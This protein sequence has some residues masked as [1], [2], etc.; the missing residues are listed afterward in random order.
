M[1][2]PS[3]E[4]PL[5]PPSPANV[6][7]DFTRPTA[8]YRWHARLALLALLGFVGFYFFLC[9]WFVRAVYRNGVLLMHGG[10]HAL[11]ALILGGVAFVLAL[12]L[13]KAMFKVKRAEET[14]R[15]ELR[16][17]S[18]PELFRFLYRLADEAGAPRPHRVFVSVRVN[19][20]V[21][22]DLSLLNLLLPSKKNLEIGLGLVNV[23]NLSEFKAVLAHEFGHFAQRSMAVGRWVYIAQQITGHLVAGRDWLD[24]LLLHAPRI[25]IRIAVVAWTLRLLVWAMRAV[26]DTAFS[27]VVLVDRALRREMEFQ[28]DLV[29]VSLSGSDALIHALHRLGAADDALD[30]AGAVAGAEHSQGRL[31]PD[32]F[33]IQSLVLESM[34]RV[35]NDP[36]YAVPPSLPESGREQHRIFPEE[37]GSPPRMWST[38]PSNQDREA[39]AKRVYLEGALDERPAWL[40]FSDPEG[41][42]RAVTAEAL[43]RVETTQE[44]REAT[45]EEAE[46]AVARRFSQLALN[47]RYRG[48]YLGRSPVLAASRVSDLFE[49]AGAN[50][51]LAAELRTL[52][53]EALSQQVE[54]LRDLRRELGVLEALKDGFL[55]AP[56]GV[57]RHRGED[58]RKRDLPGAIST[59]RAERDAVAASVAAHDRRCRSLH[60]QA[61]QSLGHGWEKYLKKLTA[62]LHYSAHVEADIDDAYGHLMNVFSV[63]I[64]DGSVS[65]SERVRLA[66][67]GSE[68]YAALWQADGQRKQVKVPE[69][70]L[71]RLEIESWDGAL[72]SR[73]DLE[74]PTSE[75]IGQWMQVV[76]SWYRAYTQPFEALRSQTLEEL[77]H[78][79]ARIAEWFLEEKEPEDAP[80]PARV[81]KEYTLRPPG[82]ERPRQHRL[83]AWDRFVTADGVLP[84]LGR[85]AVAGSIVGCVAA[86]SAAGSDARV[87][88]INGLGCHVSADIGPTHVELE[89]G[90]HLSVSVPPGKLQVT[91][92]SGDVAIEDVEVEAAGL[93][94]DYVYNVAAALPLVEWT[95]AYGSADEQSPTYLGAVRWAESDAKYFFEEPPRSVKIKGKGTTRKIVSAPPIHEAST[96]LNRAG[97][98]EERNHIIDVRARYD[99]PGSASLLYWLAGVDRLEGQA[100]AIVRERLQRNPHEVESLRAQQDLASSDARRDEVCAEHEQLMKQFPD[101][102]DMQY[103]GLRCMPD[104]EEQDAAI[105]ATFTRFPTNPWLENGAAWVHLQQNEF[106]VAARIF[107]HLRSSAPAFKSQAAMA[108]G[109]LK[110]VAPGSDY[111]AA[112]LE[113]DSKELEMLAHL[114]SGLELDETE[115]GYQFLNQG[116]LPTAVKRAEAIPS[117]LP[118]VIRFAAVSHGATPEIVER[119]LALPVD[120][121]VDA[122]TVWPALALAALNNRELDPYIKV[123]KRTLP[124]HADLLLGLL[125]KSGEKL[126]KPSDLDPQ[127]NRLPPDARARAY[128]LASSYLGDSAPLEWRRFAMNWL[129][130]PERPYFEVQ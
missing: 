15:R 83:G 111:G 114:E 42:R 125:A 32:L 35:V 101:D 33:A 53:P 94:T 113:R 41:L 97:T 76:D 21:F 7:K 124:E 60:L 69:P 62:L 20:G 123:A 96:I 116:D 89:P 8:R 128:V 95:A 55:S 49:S 108:L 54:R 36:E 34:A 2:S 70:V 6:P 74:P 45:E 19:A 3:D 93:G 12:V 112:L 58:L 17:E 31:A 91:A 9:F 100:E 1:R 51:D 22:Y 39:N 130:A 78:T 71:K 122:S 92:R 29:S 121:G 88:V 28:A 73:F 106:D 14:D 61:A 109:R 67:A 117:M 66:F 82:S 65:S 5:Y 84:A 4:A 110:R 63:V 59:V 16:P 115:R 38:H 107:N 99:A 26:L 47:P 127:L 103:I 72:Q 81:P 102:G 79:E 86:F 43:K 18:E 85:L 48:V 120:Q 50:V 105:L 75:N 25:D 129:F 126:V 119:A 13:V 44:M 104:G 57:I 64:A 11:R 37:M 27:L 77:L 80:R 10:D 118:R 23:L 52:Y 90:E 24:E 40:L 87:H 56:G 68:L 46:A 30:Q 98:E